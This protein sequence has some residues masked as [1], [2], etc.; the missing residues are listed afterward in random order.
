VQGS[1]P[2][3]EEFQNQVSSLAEQVERLQH[4]VLDLEA[5]LMR[6]EQ[7]LKYPLSKPSQPLEYS[8]TIQQGHSTLKSQDSS[9]SANWVGNQSQVNLEAKETSNQISESL[10][11]D[12][13]NNFKRD[14]K[15]Q[16][17]NLS[18]PSQI[19][20]NGPNWITSEAI[21][22]VWRSAGSIPEEERIEIIQK[23]FQR[24]A[25]GTISLKKYYESKDPDSLFEW[26]G[27]NIKYETIRRTK[28][29]QNLKE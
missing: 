9:Y 13:K 18:S 3:L 19:D 26:K 27:Y 14:S 28:L 2:A 16:Q 21:S 1:S 20:L 23:G 7:N 17:Y 11:E 8:K 15:T 10:S 4:K 12:S 5:K 24:Q 6:V 29:Y 25:H 22:A